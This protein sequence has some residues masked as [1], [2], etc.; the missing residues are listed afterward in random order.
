MAAACG[1][2]SPRYPRLLLARQYD[3]RDLPESTIDARTV[4]SWAKLLKPQK[5]VCE[6]AA[7]HSCNP[8]AAALHQ[9]GGRERPGAARRRGDR[10]RL[11][12]LAAVARVRGTVAATAELWGAVPA[13]LRPA[14]LG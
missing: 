1:R 7:R 9:R 12:Q 14:L 11:R 10:A 8:L 4:R 2:R 6:H 5:F 13:G 3:E